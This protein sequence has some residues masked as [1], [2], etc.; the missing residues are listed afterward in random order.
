LQDKVRPEIRN[1]LS[2][3]KTLNRELWRKVATSGL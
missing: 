3:A 1:G 2:G